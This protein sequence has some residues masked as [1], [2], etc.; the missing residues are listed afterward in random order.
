MAA[1]AGVLFWAVS[2]AAARWFEHPL[3]KGGGPP[4]T[5]DVE[6]SV[7]LSSFTKYGGGGDMSEQVLSSYFGGS[8]RNGFIPDMLVVYP[9]TTTAPTIA[10]NFKGKS[11]DRLPNE[12]VLTI[13]VLVPVGSP[14]LSTAPARPLMTVT[15]EG[16]DKDVC[17]K[18]PSQLQVRLE[19]LDYVKE[20][21]S[22]L[23]ALELIKNYTGKAPSVVETKSAAGACAAVNFS[24]P[25]VALRGTGW[26]KAMIKFPLEKEAIYRVLVEQTGA[27]QSTAFNFA[28]MR[29]SWF[30]VGVGAA[31]VRDQG[32]FVKG[33]VKPSIYG[34]LYV[35]KFLF[36]NEWNRSLAVV[37][38]LPLESKVD[39]ATLGLRWSPFNEWKQPDF[40]RL[41]V[42][43]GYNYHRP[44]DRYAGSRKQWRFMAGLDYKL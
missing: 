2:P 7:A 43:A 32:A 28:N 39:E 14:V 37:V 6:F 23:G 9:A 40:S 16:D 22:G 29:L 26:M 33:T 24:T 30:G 12:P 34:H 11:V 27:Q 17:L 1:V 15:Q 21:D 25:A 36:N 31:A 41:G 18:T 10:L 38:G 13:M 20:N 35:S 19:G 5:N 42:I 3:L 4:I 44:V 8:R